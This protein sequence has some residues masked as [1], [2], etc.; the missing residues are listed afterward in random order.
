VPLKAPEVVKKKVEQVAPR[1][2]ELAVAPVPV[3]PK[4][5]NRNP[6]KVAEADGLHAVC[7]HKFS[8]KLHHHNNLAVNVCIPHLK[9]HMERFIPIVAGSLEI[10][11]GE[12]SC[13]NW[14]KIHNQASLR[15]SC[16]Y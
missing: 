2:A 10:K 13:M 8:F 7:V 9:I 11:P 12:G 15:T 4:K 6:P 16:F 1:A 3:A 14:M 5:K